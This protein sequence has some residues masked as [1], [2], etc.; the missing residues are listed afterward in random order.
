MLELALIHVSE[1]GLDCIKIGKVWSIRVN[2][3]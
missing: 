3:Y 1:K 2:L